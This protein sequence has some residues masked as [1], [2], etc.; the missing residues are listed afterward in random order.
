ML[1]KP[2]VKAAG[3]ALRLRHTA[4]TRRVLH[5]TFA[6]RNCKLAE[7]K[8]ALA[9]SGRDPIRVAAAGIEEC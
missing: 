9:W 5:Y 2:F 7:E 6:L 8:I 1:R 3:D 4:E